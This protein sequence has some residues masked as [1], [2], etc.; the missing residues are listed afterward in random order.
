MR[1][2]KNRR[3][4][5]DP[6]LHLDG[7]TGAVPATRRVRERQKTRRSTVALTVEVV[8]KRFDHDLPIVQVRTRVVFSVPPALP[9]DTP[10]SFAK[11]CRRPISVVTVGGRPPVRGSPRCGVGAGTS[12]ARSSARWLRSVPRRATRS[13]SRRA[14]RAAR[15]RVRGRRRRVLAFRG[16]I[17]TSRGAKL[18]RAVSGWRRSPR[19]RAR[20]TWVRRMRRRSS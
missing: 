13:G 4:R 10:K 5:R 15:R 1:R 3:R 6:R 17:A 19:A 9:P 7:L 20:G 12:R 14:G 2:V 8:R 11:K 16:S 18:A